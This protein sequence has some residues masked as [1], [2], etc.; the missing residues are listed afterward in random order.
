M[1]SPFTQ[2]GRIAATRGVEAAAQHRLDFVRLYR[3]FGMRIGTPSDLAYARSGK[4]LLISWPGVDTRRIA[5]GAVDPVLRRTAREVAALP[6][7][8]FF[9]YRWEMD[10]P[11]L[12]SVVHD[13]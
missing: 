2:R 4:Y 10:R 5:S 12:R 9:E 7:K 13:P 6:T 11:N 3:R 1:P 8:V